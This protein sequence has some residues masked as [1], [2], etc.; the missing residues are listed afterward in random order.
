M[1]RLTHASIEIKMKGLAKTD[2]SI[3]KT[4]I[5]FL[6]GMKFGI[7]AAII[8]DYNIRRE[9]TNWTP[10]GRSPNQ[11]IRPLTDQS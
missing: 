9:S 5:A 7:M 3:K 6:K 10:P 11:P 1:G 4:H 8:T 2:A